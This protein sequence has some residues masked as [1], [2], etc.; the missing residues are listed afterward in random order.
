MTDSKSTKTAIALG[1]FDGLHKGH[2]DVI[3]NAVKQ[4]F[5]GLVPYVLIF[6][7]HPQQVLTGKM[8]RQLMTYKQLKEITEK[9]GCGIVHI[10]FDEIRNMTPDEFVKNIL[11]DKLG[12]AF[13]SC[14][15]NYRFGKNGAGDTNA[16]KELCNQHGIELSISDA[17]EYSGAPISSTRIRKEIENGNIEEANNMLGRCFSYAAE[18]VSGDRRGRTLGFPTMNQFFPDNF[19]VPKYGVYAS[20]SFIDEKWYPS[21]T[22]IGIRPTIG[23]SRPRSETSVIG[24][25][26]DLYGKS[27]PVALISYLREEIRFSTLDELSAQIKKDSAKASEIFEREENK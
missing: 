21:V 11:V 3:S 25:S 14:G 12:A 9:M 19:I 17:V 7:Q 10:S 5:N 18:V 26:G 1:N 22:N 6:D 4:S 13:V 23:N 24:F 16:L 15:F 2:A 27:I 20:K 8:P